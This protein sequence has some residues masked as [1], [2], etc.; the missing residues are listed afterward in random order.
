MTTAVSETLGPVL[1]V[2][3]EG[4]A[5]MSP[6]SIRPRPEKLSSPEAPPAARAKP[7]PKKGLRVE[8][9]ARGLSARHRD[10]SSVPPGERAGPNVSGPF[11]RP[12]APRPW[13]TARDDHATLSQYPFRRHGERTAA[14]PRARERKARAE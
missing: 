11:P 6:S 2:T 10:G 3:L 5:L 7:G 12:F 14:S 1:S 9:E 8:R 13:A 4:T